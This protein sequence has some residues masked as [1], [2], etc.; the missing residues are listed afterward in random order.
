MSIFREHKSVADRSASDRRRHKKKIED[1]IKD[2]V[3]NIVAEE[4][5]IGQDGKKKIRIPVRGIKEYRFVYGNNGQNKKVGSAPGKNITRGQQVGKTQKPS[6]EGSQAGEN[7]GEEYYEVEITLEELTHYL[8]SDLEL[9]DLDKKTLKNIVGE[10]VKRHGYRPHGIRPRLDKKKTA[11]NRIR[12]KAATERLNKELIA[13][14]SDAAREP[15]ENFP[16][17]ENDIVYR[18]IKKDIKESSNAVI[19]F[20]MD[21][22]GSMTQK[23][24]FLARS[25]Y[26][27]L[28]HFINARYENTEV[29][30]V[31]HDTNAYEV[32]E[33]KFF[34]RGN[35][36]GT[37]VSAGLDKVHEIIKK[38]FHP[39]SWNIYCFQCSD[40]DNWPTDMERACNAAESLKNVCQLF[41][42][43]EIE[44]DQERLKWMSED[45]RMSS[46]YQALVSRQFKIVKIHIK[47]DIWPAFKKL[48]GKRAQT[49]EMT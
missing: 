32:D 6:P 11:I 23:K 19:F 25:F 24:K 44:P 33:E 1:A 2:G 22:S 41:G 29:V 38:R 42:Y 8:F 12:R 5:I 31:A 27:L 28:Y 35:A 30:F 26:F 7:P 16:Y 4:S 13:S 49:M 40:G 17:R 14:G 36:G 48:L 3:H 20:L 46:A 10:K 9:P 21:I 37:I 34:K 39:S 45:S 47:E 18:H 43:C 15:E